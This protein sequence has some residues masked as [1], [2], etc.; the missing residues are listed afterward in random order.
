MK[1][2]TSKQSGTRKV[3]GGSRSLHRAGRPTQL[4][5]GLVPAGTRCPYAEECGVADTCP[6]TRPLG[7]SVDYSCGIARGFDICWRPTVA[8]TDGGSKPQLQG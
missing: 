2:K 4:E 6:T 8:I 1:T 5:S 7:N 3:N